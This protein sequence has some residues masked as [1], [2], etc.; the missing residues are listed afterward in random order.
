[1]SEATRPSAEEIILYEKDPKTKIA[2]ITFNRPEFLNAPTSAARLRYADLLRAATVDNDVKV[3]I[4]RGVGDNLGSGADLPEFMEGND[5]TDLRL[6]ELRLEDDGISDKEETNRI[7]SRLGLPVPKQRLVQTADRAVAA[8]SRIGYPVVT[9]PYNGNHGRGVSIGLATPEEVKAGF[10]RAQEHSR[11]VIVESYIQGHDHR[12]LVVNGE[13]VAATKRTPGRVIGDGVHTVHQLVDVV[14]QDPRRGVGH[15]KVLTRLEIDHQAQ[16]ML[17]RAGLTAESVPEAGREVYLRSTA[18]LSTGGT[19]TDVTDV[20]HPDN[21]DMAVRAVKAI[22]LDVG[23][24]DFISP[25]IT[26]SYKEAGGAICEVNAAPG[27][28]MHV[29]PTEGKSRDVAGPRS[30]PASRRSHAS[31]PGACPASPGRRACRARRRRRCARHA[32]PGRR[33]AGR[34]RSSPAGGC[35]RAA[36][37]RPRRRRERSRGALPSRCR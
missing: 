19:A 8:A 31:P 3:V 36:A 10:L 18:N 33:R 17:A 28:R 15:E 25:D 4:I 6:A 37:W 22:G 16:M 23:G 5:N 13:L 35:S 30:L 2:T 11:S 12:M 26:H 7:L 14:N 20:I 9:K 29:A 34:A 21:R 27:F 1:M 32:W 24:V